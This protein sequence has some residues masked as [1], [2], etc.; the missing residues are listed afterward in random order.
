VICND[1]ACLSMK[2]IDDF[3]AIYVLEQRK[4][5]E[6]KNR[7]INLRCQERKCV[8]SLKRFA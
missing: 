2:W 5:S 8:V 6:D 7:S 4:V 1:T 3:L